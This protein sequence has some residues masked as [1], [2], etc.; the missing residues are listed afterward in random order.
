MKLC[1]VFFV[2]N[3]YRHIYATDMCPI[4]S[5]NRSSFEF[6]VTRLFTVSRSF[7]VSGA[8][9]WKTL[10][11]ELRQAHVKFEHF[12]RQLKTFLSR[13]HS[14]L[15]F[16][17]I[18]AFKNFYLLSFINETVSHCL[19]C[20]CKCCQ[21]AINFLPVHLQLGKLIASQ[22]S[23]CYFFLLTARRKLD[24]LFTQFVNVTTTCQFHNSILNSFTCSNVLSSDG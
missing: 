11:T 2:P 19:T 9:Q 14:A 1:W 13:D 8:Q 21:L 22:N 7:S 3:A 17:D 20:S 12:K 16:V 18:G 10:P 24:E 6:S 23:W 4:L 5:R 15:W